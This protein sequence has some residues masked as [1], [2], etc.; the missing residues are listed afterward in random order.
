MSAVTGPQRSCG[1]EGCGRPAHNS[2]IC[3]HHTWVLDQQLQRCEA[4]LIELDI[5]LAR[6][7][8][9]TAHSD[10]VKGK[11]ESPVYFQQAASEAIDGLKDSLRGW[12]FD[13]SGSHQPDPATYLW[14]ELPDLGPR[15]DL[16]LLA[17]EIGDAY[18]RGERA[19]DAPA[20]RTVI[21]VGPCPDLMVDGQPCAGTV[22]AFIP[23][24]D[25]PP[26]MVCDT[27]NE[28]WW[29]STQWLR[30]GKRIRDL[31]ERRKNAQAIKT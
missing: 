4:L 20:N 5:T 17:D 25:R 13:V 22:N 26:R 6:A 3:R 30:T 31:I 27:A 21:P 2:T 15:G 12:A 18:R 14:T 7:S 9:A 19:I 8:K 23:A 28:H 10:K 16:P 29:A 11:G 1:I 24:D